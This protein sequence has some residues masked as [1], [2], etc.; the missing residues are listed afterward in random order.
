MRT[1]NVLAPLARLR[2]CRALVAMQDRGDEEAH[3]NAHRSA[4][5]SSV[6]LITKYEPRPSADP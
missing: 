5:Q 1:E 4:L 2:L 6:P 3:R